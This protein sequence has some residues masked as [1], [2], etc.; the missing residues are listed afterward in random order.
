MILSPFSS[1]QSTED[2]K[3]S[4]LGQLL[5]PQNRWF[6]HSSLESQSPSFTSQGSSVVQKS[7]SPTMAA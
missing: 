2:K 7:S 5:D 6:L 1:Q 3:S 4:V